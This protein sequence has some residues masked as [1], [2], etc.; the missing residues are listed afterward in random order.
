M[1]RFFNEHASG[2]TYE[3]RRLRL[4]GKLAAFGILFALL[5]VL[6]ACDGEARLADASLPAAHA[7]SSS[8]TP[9]AAPVA[10]VPASGA[11]TAADVE[12]PLEI[13]PDLG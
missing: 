3:E 1:D 6:A 8:P 4:V 13:L 2:V 5:G 10:I 9:A 11:A 12:G 7:S